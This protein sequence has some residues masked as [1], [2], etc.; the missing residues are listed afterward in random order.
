VRVLFVGPDE[1]QGKLERAALKIEDLRLRPEVLI[2]FLKIRHALRGG[3]PPPSRADIEK[4]VKDH[5][6]PAHVKAATLDG[7]CQAPL[8]HTLC[9][10]G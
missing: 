8:A 7:N 10:E 2:N 9:Q 4:L 6:L 5:G 3:P 1:M